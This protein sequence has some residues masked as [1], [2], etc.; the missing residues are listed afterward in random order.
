MDEGIM[1][2]TLHQTYT[3]RGHIK[4]IKNMITRETLWSFNI[5]FHTKQIKVTIFTKGFNLLPYQGNLN[6][7]IWKIFLGGTYL[8]NI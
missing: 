7:E 2:Y 4:G 6:I 1:N 3:Y 5:P 8:C